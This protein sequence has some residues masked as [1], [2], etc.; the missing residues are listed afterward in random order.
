MSLISTY[1]SAHSS[2]NGSR[3]DALLS[4]VPLYTAKQVQA[5]DAK[6]I[7]QMGAQGYE[8]MEQAGEAAFMALLSQWPSVR[9]IMVLCGK[10]NNGGDGFV[11][12]RLAKQH[13]IDVQLV[14]SCD[15]SELS[16]AAK[17]AAEDTFAEGINVISFDQIEWAQPEDGCVVIDALLGTGLQKDIEGELLD[18]INRVNESN[19]PVLAVDVP[20]GINSTTGA[21]Q[22]AAIH[23]RTT[24]SMVA[25]KQGLFTGAGPAYAGQVRL[26]SLSVDKKLVQTE[27]PFSHL[28]NW[29]H[30]QKKPMF[31]ARKLDV[32]KGNFGHVMI[33]GGDLGFGGAVSLAAGAALKSGAGLVSVATRSEHVAAILSRYPEAM[34]HGVSSGQDL[35]PLLERAGVIVIGPGLGQHYWGEQLLQ[36]VMKLTTPVILDADALNII[37]KKRIG[38]NLKERTSLITPHPGEAARLLDSSA[39]QVQQDRFTAAAALAKHYDS[40]V[41]L[42]GLGTLIC[43][44]DKISICS[45]G[46]PGM[47]SAGMGDVLSGIA[48]SLLAQGVVQ[49]EALQPKALHEL[50]CSA[51]SLHSASADEAAKDGQA[52]LLASDVINSLKQLLK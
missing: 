19:L 22:G 37:A 26:A 52:G 36:Q 31:A 34:V 3:P 5:L 38:H 15:V 35:Q 1:K 4:G 9:Q 12:A 6:A 18:L 23:A 25:Y 42:K 32:H 29:Q 24:I 30:L 51:V 11:V 17:K 48:A 14:L 49:Q 43:T 7:E 50:V 33:I 44:Q 45:D 27:A 20:S 16:G 2:K 8:L 21:L 46:N 10:G 47:A 41:V 39:A 40:S 13:E 28:V